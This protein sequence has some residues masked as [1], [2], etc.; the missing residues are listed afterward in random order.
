M[1]SNA[2]SYTTVTRWVKHFRQGIDVNDH[3]PFPSP[4]SEF[5]DEHI[6]LVRQIISNDLH[7][8]YDE[9]MA[10]TSLSLSRYNR[11]NYPRLPQD[12]RSYISWGTPST[13]TDEQ[14]Q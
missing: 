4:L 13:I 3:P 14:E 12:E 5:T 6:Q 7:S 2:S 10:D 8:T 1:G 9:I 11:T